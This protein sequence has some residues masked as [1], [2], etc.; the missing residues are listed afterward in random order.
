MAKITDFKIGDNIKRKDWHYPYALKENFHF[1]LD[2]SMKDLLADDWERAARLVKK[3]A[4]I[5][6]AKNLNTSENGTNFVYTSAV[7]FNKDELVIRIG[8]LIDNWTIHEIT[9]EVEE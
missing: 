5:A 3:Q 4:W 6:I 9:V 1:E 7:W 2:L 8:H